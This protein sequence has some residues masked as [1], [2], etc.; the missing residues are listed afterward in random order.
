MLFCVENGILFLTFMLLCSFTDKTDG[1][2]M[3]STA[4]SAL[5]GMG[6]GAASFIFNLS[7]LEAGDLS[8][9][10]QEMGWI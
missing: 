10:N 9:W 1:I 4:G 3:E 6:A 2:W 7:S 5:L 8:L